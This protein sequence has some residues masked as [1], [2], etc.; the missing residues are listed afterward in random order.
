MGCII[1]TPQQLPL[2]RI[3][4]SVRLIKEFS[5]VRTYVLPHLN[6]FKTTLPKKLFKIQVRFK[7]EGKDPLPPF[8]RDGKIMSDKPSYVDPDSF[9]LE[10]LNQTPNQ[11][12]KAPG[13]NVPRDEVTEMSEG[14][15]ELLSESTLEYF[16]E[17]LEEQLDS[18]GSDCADYDVCLSQGVLTLNLGKHGTYVLNKQGPNKQIW[19][20]SPVSGPKRYDFIGEQWVYKGQTLTSLVTNELVEVFGHSIDFYFINGKIKKDLDLGLI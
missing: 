18:G 16:T 12:R 7:S 11:L 3:T 2:I 5:Q 4:S 19:L 17:Y 20:S 14:L 8:E 6:S 9:I 13:M 1:M 15:F 10:E